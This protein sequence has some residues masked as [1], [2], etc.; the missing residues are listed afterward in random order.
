MKRPR[1][2][3]TRYVPPSPE[4]PHS[5]LAQLE[6]AR[7]RHNFVPF[8]FN[9]LKVLA[10]KQQLQPLIEHAKLKQQQRAQAKK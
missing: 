6:N 2:S 1:S 3:D 8:L 10:E 5:P 4:P 9:F 7:R